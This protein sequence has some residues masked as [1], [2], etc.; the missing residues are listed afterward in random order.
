M[1]RWMPVA[2][3]LSFLSCNAGSSAVQSSTGAPPQK[4][5]SDHILAVRGDEREYRLYAP[6]SLQSGQKA[7]LM[8]VLHGGMGNAEA[9]ETASAMSEVAA[10]EQFFAAYPEGTGA[11]MPKMKDRR[12]WN[13]G[14]CCGIAVKQ[15][16]DDVGFISAMIDDL[17]ASY[18]I[19][20]SRVYVTGM[21]NGA[22]MAYRMACEAPE[23]IAAVI[24]I[25]GTLAVDDA[26]RAKD[27]A[28]LHIHGDRD[29]NV[30]FEG[31][32]GDKSV[33]GVAHRSVPDTMALLLASRKSNGSDKEELDGGKVEHT[34]YNCGAGAPVELIVVKGGGHSWPGGRGKYASASGLNASEQA[35]NFAKRFS[36]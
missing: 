3:F 19:D 2:L 11:K 17:A 30:P 35:W 15:N 28:V 18:P 1:V 32:I 14:A 33:S 6:P 10:R 23:K 22:M 27:V 13:A 31:G 5:W 26:S 20:K 9:I 8:I 34:T 21:S 29:T 16:V 4:G 12:T 24:P 36:K 25:A 7:P